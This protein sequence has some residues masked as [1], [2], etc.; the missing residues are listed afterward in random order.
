[1]ESRNKLAGIVLLVLIGM[2]SFAA[3]GAEGDKTLLTRDSCAAVAASIVSASSRANSVASLRQRTK[4]A[5]LE[6]ARGQ[7]I[8][9]L[10]LHAIEEP[11]DI[12]LDTYAG[13]ILDQVRGGMFSGNAEQFIQGIGYS[14]A[15]TSATCMAILLK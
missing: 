10:P 6:F 5:Y 3:N 1:M 9:V 15:F 14:M 12:I 13:T 2:Q 8:E 4:A 11:I 7:G